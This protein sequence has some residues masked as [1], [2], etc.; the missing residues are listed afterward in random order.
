[1]GGFG[2]EDAAAHANYATRLCQCHL[3][4]AWIKMMPAA[5]GTR[6]GRRTDTGEQT[7]TAFGLGDDLMSHNQNVPRQQSQ[8]AAAY[9]GQNFFHQLIARTDFPKARDRKNA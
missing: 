8:T 5:P 2:D 9:A 4:K 1:M 7:Q 6:A 3:D